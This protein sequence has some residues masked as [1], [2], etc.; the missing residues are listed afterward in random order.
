MKKLVT[1]LIASSLFAGC[2][3]T[4]SEP[5]PEPKLAIFYQPLSPADEQ[6]IATAKH[7]KAM[8]NVEPCSDPVD[9]GYSRSR[10]H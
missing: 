9:N 6:A 3:S 5:Q 7:I 8:E 2:A 4:T 1:I 10:C